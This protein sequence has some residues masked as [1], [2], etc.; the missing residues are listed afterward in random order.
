MTVGYIESKTDVAARRRLLQRLGE[1]LSIDQ[2]LHEAMGVDTDGLDAAVQ[3]EIRSE[4]PEW[5][6]TGPGPELSRR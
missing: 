1:G 3:R 6:R 4:F 5:A 2:A